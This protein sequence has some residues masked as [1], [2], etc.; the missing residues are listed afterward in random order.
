MADRNDLVALYARVSTHKQ[1]EELQLPRLRRLAEARGLTIYKEYQD[2]ASGKDGNRPAWKE[3]MLDAQEGKFGTIMAVKLDRIMRSVVNLN[4][5]LGQLEV[6]NVRLVTE[7]MGE[8][9]PSKP[10]SKLIMQ[11]I[12]AIAEWERETIS[13]RTKDALDAKKASGIKLGRKPLT[14]LPLKD[15][16][17]DRINGLSWNQIAKKYRVSKGTVINRK[18]M[19]EEYIARVQDDQENG[20]VNKGD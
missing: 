9:D 10:N 14:D 20:A 12:G 6:Y 2:E 5:V 8:V 15:M 13:Q 7:D 11:V 4:N 3:L 1:D 19:I 17:E 18:G 16:A